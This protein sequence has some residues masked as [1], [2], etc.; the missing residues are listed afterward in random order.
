MLKQRVMVPAVRPRQRINSERIPNYSR[1]RRKVKKNSLIVLLAFHLLITFAFAITVVAL[2]TKRN[3]TEND[4]KAKVRVAKVENQDITAIE[5]KQLAAFADVK[6][7]V[8]EEPKKSVQNYSKEIPQ[9][10]ES[11]RLTTCTLMEM[12]GT[13]ISERTGNQRMNGTGL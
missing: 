10:E 12:V 9:L 5:N 4:A 7:T 11:S 2:S 6:T 13:T 1:K 8:E 3:K